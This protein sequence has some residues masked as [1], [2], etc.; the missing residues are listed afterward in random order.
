[1]ELQSLQNPNN[2]SLWPCKL[3]PIQERIMQSIQLLNESSN[4]LI[5]QHV[6]NDGPQKVDLFGPSYN[7]IQQT[8]TSPSNMLV[9]QMDN[10]INGPDCIKQTSM[11]FQQYLAFQAEIDQILSNK[12]AN[13][14]SVDQA[15]TNEFDFFKDMDSAKDM[16]TWWSNEFEA[17]SAS[18]TSWDSSNVLDHQQL[19][20]KY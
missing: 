16:M 13:S 7:R 14:I 19:E 1:M 4:P 6:L 9:N 11:E 3:N 5:M 18:S 17:N 8:Y 15:Q 2:I 12:R 20:L 10:F